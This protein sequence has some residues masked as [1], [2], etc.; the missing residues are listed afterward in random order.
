[1]PLAFDSFRKLINWDGRV[2]RIRYFTNTVGS[3]W[4]DDSTW[5]LSGVNTY[6]SGLVQSL[7]LRRGSDDAVLVEQGRILETDK[8]FFIAGSL[9]TTSG[10]RLPTL[11]I[12]GLNQVYRVITDGVNIPTINA[13]NVYKKVYGR[14]IETGSLT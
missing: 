14:I 2:I 13:D 7:N 6:V 11:T 4:D 12:S 9:D 1:M 3:V 10:L 8:V 5:T